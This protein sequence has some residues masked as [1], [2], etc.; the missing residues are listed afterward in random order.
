MDILLLLFAAQ[1][2]VYDRESPTDF[3][4]IRM[5]RHGD[6]GDNVGFSILSNLS[7]MYDYQRVFERKKNRFRFYN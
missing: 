4:R 2:A 3:N 5:T 6:N 7:V 1:V